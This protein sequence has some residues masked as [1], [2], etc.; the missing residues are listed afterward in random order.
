MTG[1]GSPRLLVLVVAGVLLTLVP[2]LL[3]AGEREPRGPDAAIE[4]AV[5]GALAEQRSLL[6]LLVLPTEAP[7]LLPVLLIVVCACLRHRDRA[8]AALAVLAPA[9]AVAA[10]TWLL[11]PAF[12]R[13]YDDH[14]AY[15]SG[16][17][18]SL[19]AVLT[20]LAVLA[21]PGTA[22]AVV[23]TLGTV[24]LLAVGLGMVGSRFHYASDVLGAAGFGVAVTLTVAWALHRADPRSR[25]GT[26]AVSDPGTPPDRRRGPVR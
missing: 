25:G 14:L 24:L 7:V 22:T 23:V 11:K 8:G 10:N 5:L 12:G 1:P 19:V 3:F 21:R 6:R 9:I 13:V 17:T 15:P 20:V 2:G 26:A 4:D 16:H 18:V